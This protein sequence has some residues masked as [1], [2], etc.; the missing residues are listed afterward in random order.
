MNLF[1]YTGALVTRVFHRSRLAAEMDEELRAHIEHRADDLERSGMSR[2]DAERRA[3]IEMGSREHYKE[4]SYKAMGGNG[5]E[6]IGQDV[7][8]AWRMLR[9]S[10]GF[11]AVAIVTLAFAIGA[12][13]V[14]FSLL[15]ALVL[16]PV[17]VPDGANLYQL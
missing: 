7:R 14:V 10:P 9:K 15:N 6:V 4:E 2:E 5:L 1:A 11:T 8:V 3:K 17:N 13:A 16:R 12:N